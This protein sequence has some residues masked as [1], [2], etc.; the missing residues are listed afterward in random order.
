MDKKRIVELA[1]EALE[2]QK[3]V[4]DSEI[5]SLRSEIDRRGTPAP[6]KRSFT[7]SKKQRGK[8][9]AERKA[10]SERMKKIWAE[11]NAKKVASKAPAK[12][13]ATI[14]AKTTV[15]TAAAKPT[16]TKPTT[17]TRPK[18]EAEKKALSL[19]MKEIW[20]KKKAAAAA[21]EVNSN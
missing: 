4:I 19:K 13:K 10:H 1:I 18:T 11:R 2:R 6:E 14:K 5:E 21:A 7:N 15:K 20:K 9:D 16:K 12:S 17:K 3:A 8:S